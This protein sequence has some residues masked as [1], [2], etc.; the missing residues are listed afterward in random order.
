MQ[1]GFFE[2]L[3]ATPPAVAV[4][5]HWFPWLE[6][7]HVVF[8]ALVAG[9]IFTIDARLLGLASR[10]LPITYL[11]ERLL[12]WTWG[13]FAGA[14][15]TGALLFSSRAALYVTNKPFLI[16][17]LLLVLLGVNMLLFHFVTLRGARHRDTG[18]PGAAAR[19]AGLVSLV[20]WIGVI[21]FGRWIGFT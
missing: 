15:L 2:W 5:E 12:P 9:T 16:K 7:A 4:G 13:A 3:Q 6:S 20:L 11:T 19:V 10:A 18:P 8:L 1:Q 17:M 21:G 14:A